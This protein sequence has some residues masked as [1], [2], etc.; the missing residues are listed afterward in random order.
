MHHEVNAL[1]VVAKNI[2]ED[3]CKNETCNSKD[4]QHKHTRK[5]PKYILFI[6]EKHLKISKVRRKHPRCP[7]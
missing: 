4:E 2:E 1:K 3:V 7:A 6:K 5:V